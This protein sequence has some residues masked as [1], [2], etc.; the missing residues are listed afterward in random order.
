MDALVP[1]GDVGTY[2]LNGGE[3]RLSTGDVDVN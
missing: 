1:G 2:H 3:D